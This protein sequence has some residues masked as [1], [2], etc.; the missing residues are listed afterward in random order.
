MPGRF[1]TEAER[2]ALRG[3]PDRIAAEELSKF[4]VL[5]RDD[6]QF[7]GRHRREHNRLGIALQLCTIRWLGFCP[8]DLTGVPENAVETV[9]A[10]LGISPGVLMQYGQRPQT[11][12]EHLREVLRYLGFRTPN[13]ADMTALAEWLAVQAM[14]QPDPRVLL[15]MATLHLRTLRIVRP[16]ITRLERLVVTM[17]SRRA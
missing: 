3:F 9:A 6:L 10:Q 15:Q 2:Q 17:R 11:R 1:L 5:G 14:S 4:F 13:Q 16:G 7:V 8:D 12:T